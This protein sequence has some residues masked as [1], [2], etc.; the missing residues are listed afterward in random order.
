VKTASSF[1]DAYRRRRCLVPADAFYEWKVA[2]KAKQPYAIAM[3]HR[4]PFA[5]AGLCENWKNPD[6]GDWLRTF[7]V[8]TTKH[9]EL[10]ARLHDR[11]PVILTTRNTTAGLE[12]TLTRGN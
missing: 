11:M 12:M 2:G 8:L 5:F 10:V 3:R 4:Q 1:R 7:T 9:N 6:S